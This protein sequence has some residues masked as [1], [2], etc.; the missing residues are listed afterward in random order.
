MLLSELRHINA[1]DGNLTVVSQKVA[2][3][4]YNIGMNK[5]RIT[6]IDIG[7]C[8]AMIPII[9]THVF[10]RAIPNY[11]NGWFSSFFLLLGVTIFFFLSGVSHSFRKPVKPL[12]FV[13]YIIKD[14]LMYMVPFLWFIAMRLW[15]YGQWGTWDKAWFEL[16][17]YPVSCLWVCWLLAFISSVVDIGLLIS[18]FA[19]KLK[20][21]FVCGLLAIGITVLVILRKNSVI[22]T[23]SQIG[24]DYF[25]AYTPT[26]FIGFLVGDLF[27]K[28]KKNW[29][30]FLSMGVGLTGLFFATFFGPNLIKVDFYKHIWMFYLCELC[31]LVFW[32]GTINLL[33][34]TKLQKP[35]S[36]CGRFTMEAY[37]LHLMLIK[38]WGSMPEIK[39]NPLAI[40]FVCI[41]LAL[42]LIANTAVVT[43]VTYYI[44][45]I[46]FILFGKHY[47]RYKFENNFFDKI[48]QI[49]LKE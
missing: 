19:P 25:V 41:G 36:F 48:R 28:I 49:A 35:L 10:Q 3:Y 17:Q 42:L 21:V 2:H 27:T 40:T 37:F 11:M 18:Y 43:L 46:H 20:K 8:L 23:D 6:A 16:M 45:F 30:L 15:F 14:G 32:I 44:P 47:S 29:I 33:D 39:D 22:P 7:K 31:S 12:G 5:L 24:Y 38:V 4:V 26:Y 13:Y 34:K 1:K 9:L